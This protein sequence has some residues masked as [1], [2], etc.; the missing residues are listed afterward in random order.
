MLHSQRKFR[1]DEEVPLILVVN[2]HYS[3]LLY[4]NLSAG[5]KYRFA[6]G[7]NVEQFLQNHFNAVQVH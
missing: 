1:V 2:D 7:P 5:I 6:V 4:L 3:C